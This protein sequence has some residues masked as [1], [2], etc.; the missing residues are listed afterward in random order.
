MTRAIDKPFLQVDLALPREPYFVAFAAALRD[1]MPSHQS[2]AWRS[3]ARC[4]LLDVW[5]GFLELMPSGNP[6]D[7]TRDTIELWASW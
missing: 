3:V 7:V 1:A 2:G 5:A 4:C 6:R